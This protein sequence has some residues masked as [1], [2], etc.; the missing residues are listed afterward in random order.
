MARVRYVYPIANSSYVWPH[1]DSICKGKWEGGVEKK[2]GKWWSFAMKSPLA[3]NYTPCC[4][5]IVISKSSRE[6]NAHVIIIIRY[7][8]YDLIQYWQE[9]L[10][11]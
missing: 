10:E 2:E 6:I 4:P 1:F 9:G 8:F 3:P 7:S 11:G 5:L